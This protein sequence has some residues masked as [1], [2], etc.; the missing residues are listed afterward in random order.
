MMFL[1]KI[2]CCIVAIVLVKSVAVKCQESINME[3]QTS[4][5]TMSAITANDL[6]CLSELPVEQLLKIRKSLQEVSSM[7]VDDN[8]QLDDRIGHNEED[9]EQFV[10]DVLLNDFGN[11]SISALP[12]MIDKM[13]YKKKMFAFKF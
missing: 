6:Q 2:Y 8:V 11:E 10:G 12:L 7:M 5:L 3:N 13:K 4:L 9:T 1:Y